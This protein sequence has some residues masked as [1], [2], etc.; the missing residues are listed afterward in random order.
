MFADP[1]ENIFEADPFP[2][3]EKFAS[4]LDLDKLDIRVGI[5]K[6]A[7]GLN[8][9]FEYLKLKVDLGGEERVIVSKLENQYLPQTLTRYPINSVLVVK[10]VKPTKIQGE[11]SH[12]YLLCSRNK[13]VI[14]LLT[15]REL[16]GG[17]S[18]SG[19]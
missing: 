9:G 16:E 6:S 10:N 5:I 17:L 8:G 4:L 11:F 2:S 19:V 12:G 18:V 14:K 15:S 7:E 13:G 3:T 1:F